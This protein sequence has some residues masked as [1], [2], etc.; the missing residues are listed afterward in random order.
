MLLQLAAKNVDCAL[1][2]KVSR[3]KRYKACSD[4]SGG[5]SS[6]I[7]MFYSQFSQTAN[8]RKRL[9][10]EKEE[11]RRECALTYKVSRSKRYKACSDV[12]RAQGFEP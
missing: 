12:V 8:Q 1:T 6:D 5:F 11:Q 9:Q 4:V 3:S 2:Y 10:F 7:F